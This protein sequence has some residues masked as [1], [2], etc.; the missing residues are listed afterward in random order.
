MIKIE[1]LY[2]EACNLYGDRFNMNYLEASLTDAE[3]IYTS[4]N[5][6]PR[7][8]TEDVDFIYLG[9]M[10]E[11]EQ[12]YVIARLLPY[13]ERIME[14]IEKDKVF[15]LTGNAFEIFGSYI[16]CEDGRRIDGLGIYEG[17]AVR[18]MM[19]RF[20]SL[21]LGTVKDE[22]GE[23]IEVVGFKS[24]FTHTY[25]D[26]EG[27]YA[28]KSVRGC[29]INPDSDLEGIRLHNFF[30]TYLIGPILIFNPYFAKYLLRLAGVESP[31]LAFE[32]ESV[33]AYEVRLKEF[34]DPKR[35]Y[36]S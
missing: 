14:L 2:T 15:L 28:F 24:Q 23:D 20:N 30:G 5:Q 17:F 25:C 11:K 21:F 1:A 8:A 36:E 10:P 13:R 18:R 19:N 31:T 6:T 33:D 7:F 12:E 32:K 22:N 27:C 4:L 26:N 9:P 34:H 3:F 29:G 35:V 16:Q